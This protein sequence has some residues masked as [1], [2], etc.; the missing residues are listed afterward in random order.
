[1]SL[2]NKPPYTSA[3]AVD[4]FFSRIANIGEPKPPKAIDSQWVEDFGFDTAHPAAI[5]SML[6]WLGVIDEEGVSTGV[7]NSLRVESTREETL[8]RLIR[9]SYAELFE[10]VD[11]EGASLSDVRGGFIN[12]YSLG[13][14]ARHVK[15]FKTL[16]DHAGIALAISSP[17]SSKVTKSGTTKESRA[18]TP[19]PPKPKTPAPRMNRAVAP[20]QVSIALNVEIPA[21]WNEAEIQ[22]R[23]EIVNRALSG[24]TA[25]ATA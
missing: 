13:D 12:A 9:E 11:V 4:Q 20:Q 24:A 8:A 1:M 10:R 23:I 6:K 18:N 15:C 22:E 25:A 14:V 3:D 19:K 17:Q 16:C 7:W 5:P 2:P 21:E